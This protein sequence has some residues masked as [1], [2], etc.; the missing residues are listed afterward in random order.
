MNNFH[1]QAAFLLPIINKLI[2][3]PSEVMVSGEG[4]VQPQVVIVSPTRE[5]AIQIYTEARKFA[6][7]SVVKVCLIYGG[8]AVRHQAESISV[9]ACSTVL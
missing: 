7:S 4:C 6:H 9:R 8:T 5:L 2:E 3:F 1:F